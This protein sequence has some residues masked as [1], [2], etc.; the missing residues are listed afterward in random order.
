[1]ARLAEASQSLRNARTVVSLSPN[2]VEQGS[3][4]LNMFQLFLQNMFQGPTR[5]T[6][7]KQK[8]S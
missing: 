6:E 2:E 7:K 4:L 3:K 5:G 1:V 8:N